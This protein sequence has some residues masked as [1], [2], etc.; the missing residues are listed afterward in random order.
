MSIITTGAGVA[1]RSGRRPFCGVQASD[2]PGASV[3]S[4]GRAGQWP[5]HAGLLGSAIL[6]SLLAAPGAWAATL[7]VSAPVA[8][9][10]GNIDITNDKPNTLT[11]DDWIRFGNGP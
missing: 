10:A 6:L 3:Q 8:R 4:A 9:P 1:T 11:N 5:L 2:M 7:T